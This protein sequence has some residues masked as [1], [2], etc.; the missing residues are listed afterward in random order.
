MGGA[1]RP[2]KIASSDTKSVRNSA[3]GGRCARESLQYQQ[4]HKHFQYFENEQEN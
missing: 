1:R 2:R 3:T 4:N